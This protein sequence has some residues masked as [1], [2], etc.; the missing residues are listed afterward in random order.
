[1][2]I[3]YGFPR[4]LCQNTKFGLS[5]SKSSVIFLSKLNMEFNLDTLPILPE[6]SRF[7]SLQAACGPDDKGLLRHA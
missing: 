7:A 6:V 1:M 5:Q 4:I 3:E 2:I